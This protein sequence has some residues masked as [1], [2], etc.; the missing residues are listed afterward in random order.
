M[1]GF[2]HFDFEAIWSPMFLFL[3]AAIVI[4]YLYF[5]GPWQQKHFPKEAQLGLFKKLLFIL[6]ALLYYL[7]N[8]GPLSLLGHIYFS[9]HMVNMAIS[10]LM[11][12]PLVLLAMPNYIWKYIF[13]RPVFKKLRFLMHPIFTA[14]FFNMSFSI[15][16][17][18]V[19]HDYVMTNFTIHRV[20]YFVM[21]IAAFMMWWHIV[22]PVK[23]W[24]QLTHV[25][26]MAYIFIDG[27]LLTPA[28]AFII[29]SPEPMYSIYNS[30]ELWVKAMGFCVPG[31]TSY[32]FALFEDS[33]SFQ[34]LSKHEDQ[35]LGGIVMK[36]LQ[37]LTFFIILF[38]VF[39]QWFKRE[40]IDED[41]QNEKLLK[42][43]AFDNK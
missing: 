22:S 14:V 25:K 7:A 36:L 8:E 1:L 16:H 9:F 32:L 42:Q 43:Y 37:E 33:N 21:L 23:E 34:L 2:Q 5:V 31:D 38:Y 6:A 24:N 30:A 28:C 17:F 4:A 3:T 10:Y 26:R 20:Y 12:P 41:E 15:Y 18:P 19:V 40:H 11:V 39:K 27:V 13:D 35:Q 29:F